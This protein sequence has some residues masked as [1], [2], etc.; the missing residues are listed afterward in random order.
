VYS[1]LGKIDSINVPEPQQ[2]A[3]PQPDE[4]TI[5]CTLEHPSSGSMTL[6]MYSM[7]TK[8]FVVGPCRVAVDQG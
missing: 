4:A 3:P 6:K 8:E 2:G 1:V 5:V 7:A